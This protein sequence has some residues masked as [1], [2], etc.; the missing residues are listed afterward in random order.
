M[1]LKEKRAA[2]EFVDTRLDS[3][4][5]QVSKQAKF[6]VDVEIDWDTLSV[7]DYSH[8][9]DEAWPKVYFKPLIAAF[10]DMCAD[11]LSREA[12]QEG[13]KKVVICNHS[14]NYSAQKWARFKDGT[15]TLNHSPI[16]NVNEVDISML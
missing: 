2:K 14:D 7:D 8:L 15:L 9:Y 16:I 4:L 6:E 10:K 5:A 3:L 11:D 12:L 13:V 1:G